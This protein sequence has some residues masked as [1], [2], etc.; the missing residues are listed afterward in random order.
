MEDTQSR[1]PPSPSGIFVDLVTSD[2]FN[3]GSVGSLFETSK[4]EGLFCYMLCLFVGL[5]VGSW[6]LFFSE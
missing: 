2:V 4:C 1:H 3:L 5:T 6:S